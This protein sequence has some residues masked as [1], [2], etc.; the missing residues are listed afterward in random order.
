[1]RVLTFALAVLEI[2][3]VGLQRDQ[4]RFVLKC[5]QWRV[6]IALR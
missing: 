3:I 6:S 5:Q 4:L 1:M 2:D